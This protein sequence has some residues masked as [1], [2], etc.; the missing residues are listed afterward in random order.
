MKRKQKKNNLSARNEERNPKP[1]LK[2][3]ELMLRELQWI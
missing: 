3:P 1:E 2:A